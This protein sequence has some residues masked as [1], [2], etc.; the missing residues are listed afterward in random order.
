MSTASTNTK[1]VAKWMRWIARTISIMATVAWLLIFLDI[2]ACEALFGTICLNWEM[3]LLAGMVMASVTSV[4]MAWR[5]ESIGGLVMFL[6]GFVFAAIAY[7]TSQPYQTIS[8]LVT[9]VPFL[10][11]GC[12]FLAS[13][14]LDQAVNSNGP[15]SIAEG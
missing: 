1:L 2:V 8:V 15:V 5:W 11:A 7:V 10:I 9:G 12:L 13:W 3:A 14:W 6:W 4:L